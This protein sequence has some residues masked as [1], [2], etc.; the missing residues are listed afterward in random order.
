MR[1]DGRQKRRGCAGCTP[2]GPPLP[3]VIQQIHHT[4]VRRLPSR[5]LLTRFVF[6]TQYPL[7]CLLAD[8]D[9]LPFFILPDYRVFPALFHPFLSDIICCI[10]PDTKS[11]PQLPQ[12]FPQVAIF[13]ISNVF[14]KINHFCQTRKRSFSL[15]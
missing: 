2:R 11:Y 1:P 13:L 8:R 9:A 10:I 6:L 7:Y 15:F 5:D 4:T 14:R 3:S 12:S